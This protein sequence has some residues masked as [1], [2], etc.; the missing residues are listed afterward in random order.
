MK[1]KAQIQNEIIYAMKRRKQ[2]GLSPAEKFYYIGI[3]DA[4]EWVQCSRSELLH[5]DSEP[6]PALD[7]G[8]NF[9]E[10]KV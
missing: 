2:E 3:R 5:A 7:E 9:E 4:L 6:A 10:D 8:I 1:L